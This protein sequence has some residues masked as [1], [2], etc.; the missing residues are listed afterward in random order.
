MRI[1]P[2]ILKEFKLLARDLHGVAVLFLMPI[3]FM[4]IMSAAL[5]RADAPPLPGKSILIGDSSNAAL[6]TRLQTAG[7]AIELAP[8]EAL[9]EAQAALQ[10][11]ETALVIVNPNAADTPLATQQPLALWLNPGADPLWLAPLQGLL[12]EHHRGARVAEHLA[13]SQILLP[14][15][16][17]AAQANAQLARVHADIAAYLDTPAWHTHYL[18]RRGE[19]VSRPDSVQHSVPA[20]LIFGMFF[21]MIPLSN[22]MTLERA[23]NTLT[24]LRMAQAPAGKLLTAKLMPYFLIN[25]LQ[26]LG[27]LAL[28]HFVLPRLGLPAFTPQGAFYP[29]LLLSAATSLAALGYALLVSVHAKSSE[30]AVVLGGGGI[31]IMAA[32]GGIMVPVHVMPAA[33]QHIAQLSP[34]HWALAAFQNL[35]LNRASLAHILPQL[36]LLLAFAAVTLTLAAMRYRQQLAR[37]GRF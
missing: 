26:F 22:V 12:H 9:H 4:L 24:R 2:A 14:N 36:A 29:Y 31:I 27:M 10:S 25:Q 35:L 16:A 6:L 13:R 34:M 8:Q 30:H 37:Q 20:W 3:I 5:S 1:T 28:G 11:G 18:D 23:S 7:L 32:L 15:P 33:M 17:F 21:I 19:Q